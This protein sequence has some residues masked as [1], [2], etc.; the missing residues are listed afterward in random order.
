MHPFLSIIMTD[1]KDVSLFTS[2]AGRARNDPQSR[3]T[4]IASILVSDFLDVLLCTGTRVMLDF[5]AS[6][7]TTLYFAHP[8]TL[9]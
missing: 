3:R 7:Q 2:G 1:V 9:P 8:L 6:E 5:S 4:P